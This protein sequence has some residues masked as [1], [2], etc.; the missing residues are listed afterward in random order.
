M[1]IPS[2]S[3]TV[4]ATCLL[5]PL[6]LLGDSKTSVGSKEG[7]LPFQATKVGNGYGW[8]DNDNGV[9]VD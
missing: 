6:L 5:T 1:K 8:K 4:F 9:K 3:A 7:G 2:F